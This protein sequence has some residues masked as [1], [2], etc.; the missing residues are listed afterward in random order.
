MTEAS[1]S[2]ADPGQ[3][4][5]E[6][7]VY[8]GLIIS[9]L[10]AA[11]TAL[12]GYSV[13]FVDEYRKGKI[14]TVNTRIEKLYGP[15][16][17]YSV[18]SKRAW[19]ELRKFRGDKPYYFNDNDKPGEEQV[20]IWRRWMKAV[21]M[22]LNLKM[23]SAI[24]ENAQL[25]D[26]SRIYPVLVDFIAHVESYKATIAR[27][28]DTDDISDPRHRTVRANAAVIDYP[29]TLD[30]CIAVRLKAALELRDALEQSWTGFLRD[31]SAKKFND[32]CS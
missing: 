25:L 1:P 2:S 18:A 28:K 5:K 16:Y 15:L 20:E 14:R 12:I 26:G 31:E 32:D 27:W 11:A 7:S 30:D 6:H 17:A 21:F 9:I 23:E 8:T 29:P 19:T 24:I 13:S 4:K 3:G 22:P 10:V